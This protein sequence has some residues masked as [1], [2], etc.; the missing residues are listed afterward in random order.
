MAH[1]CCELVWIAAVL[2]DLHIPID[3]P[4]HLYS[5][6]KAASHIAKNPVFHERTKHIQLD[7]HVVRQHFTSGF[8]V[9]LYI[10]FA[11]Q[12]ADLFTKALPANVLHRCA[13]KLGVS[14]FLHRRA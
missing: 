4:I 2:R 7:C 13:V 3:T 11:S 1:A 6:N 12:P 8:I 5:D 9:P 14:N 10:Q